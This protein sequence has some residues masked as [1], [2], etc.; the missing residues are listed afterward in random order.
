[1]LRGLAYVDSMP[2]KPTRRELLGLA[3]VM[4][5]L[6]LA[7]ASPAYVN[8]EQGQRF[9]LVLAQELPVAERKPKL[10]L[11]VED[12]RAVIDASCFG[13]PTTVRRIGERIVLGIA[14]DER[15]NLQVAEGMIRRVEPLELRITEVESGIVDISVSRPSFLVF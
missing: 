7:V 4:V 12:M 5:A 3:P 2:A 15:D 14:G 10:D 8:V 11:A 1:M 13:P 6:A 9:T